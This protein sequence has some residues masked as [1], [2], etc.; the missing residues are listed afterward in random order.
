MNKLLIIF[1]ISV[2]I[3][4]LI[5]CS[6]NEPAKLGESEALKLVQ[7]YED[8]LLPSADNNQKVIQFHNKEELIKSYLQVMTTNFAKK[9]TA[10][11]FEER[12]GALYLKP[13]EP[14]FF[15]VEKPYTFVMDNNSYFLKQNSESMLMGKY[16]LKITIVEQN[17]DWF[18][19]DYNWKFQ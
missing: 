18:I 8:I 9:Q 11:Y 4:T 10:Q 5:G 3:L 1:V 19:S 12:T 15:D 14:V 16:S 2:A 13:F 7:N 17:G 6:P